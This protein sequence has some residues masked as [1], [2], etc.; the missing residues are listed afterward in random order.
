[1][2]VKQISA[3][4]MASN[5]F[6]FIFFLLV[7]Y[8]NVIPGDAAHSSAACKGYAVYNLTF[9]GMWNKNDHPTDF[10]EGNAHFS[11]IIGASHDSHYKMWAPGIKASNGIKAVA[12]TG[13]TKLTFLIR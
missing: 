9:I 11:P 4:E 2:F 13:E 10:P 7:Q 3:T 6:S 1:M 5:Y 12:E 8:W